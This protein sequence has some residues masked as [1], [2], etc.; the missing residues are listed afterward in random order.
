MHL[1]GTSLS[2]FVFFLFEWGGVDAMRFAP[3]ATIAHALPAPADTDAGPN[4]P[5]RA[6][7]P[8]A[9]LPFTFVLP[10][11]FAVLANAQLASFGK[12]DTICMRWLYVS[13][14]SYT[15]LS[16]HSAHAVVFPVSPHRYASAPTPTS[17]Y[18]STLLPPTPPG[19]LPMVRSISFVANVG[20]E[21]Q[22]RQGEEAQSRKR[23]VSNLPVLRLLRIDADDN[24]TSA[25]LGGTEGHEELPTPVSWWSV[26]RLRSASTST[27]ACCPAY[28]ESEGEG[29]ELQTPVPGLYLR[30]AT[31]T[32]TPYSEREWEREGEQVGGKRK[33]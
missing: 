29:E 30:E 16:I 6:P 13:P 5:A 22:V 33:R 27:S 24:A 23:A 10:P 26:R 2:L 19:M 14:A 15:W 12:D 21:S 11:A 3:G 9:R 17:P 18:V 8:A 1:T 31:P 7:A 20:R 25:I 4:P 28:Y 32:L